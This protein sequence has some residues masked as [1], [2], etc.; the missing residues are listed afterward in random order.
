LESIVQK[1]IMTRRRWH[2]ENH[3]D[4]VSRFLFDS[5][6]LPLSA[7]KIYSSLLNAGIKVSHHTIGNYL[8]AMA[9]AFLFYRVQRYDVRGKNI[10]TTQEK[11]YAADIGFKRAVIG[12]TMLSDMGRNL[13]NVVY[14]ELLRRNSKVFV[15][16][17][18]ASEIDFVVQTREG[19]TEY[20]QV[21]HTA[22][23]TETLA[24]ELR[25]LRVPKDNYRKFLLTTDG[26]DGNEHGI[27]V[28]DIER[29]LLAKQ[30]TP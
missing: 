5:V 25:P 11:F 15:G 22:K 19:L 12:K 21:A 1:D 14:L 13:E 2:R 4:R 9:D 6:G 3:F 8:D 27:E 24:R 20:Y 7:S 17:A 29:W 30:E 18:D 10:L 16:K 23:E 26:F 28:R